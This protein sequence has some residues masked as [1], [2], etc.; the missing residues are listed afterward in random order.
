[1]RRV[2]IDHA[3]KRQSEK[4][5]AGRERVTFTDLSVAVEN[6]GIDLLAL[7]QSLAA[8]EAVDERLSL[9]VKPRYFVDLSVEETADVMGLSPATVKRDWAYARAWL[10]GRMSD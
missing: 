5:G 3:R 2:L 1:M 10:F 7:D 4:R 8:L 9:I 6:P